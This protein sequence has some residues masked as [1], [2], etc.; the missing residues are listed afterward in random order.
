MAAAWAMLVVVA[1][2]LAAASRLASQA[3]PA[4]ARPTPAT[5]FQTPRYF[6]DRMLVVEAENFT[7]VG[8]GEG[9]NWVPIR[10]GE[11]NY[12][13]TTIDDVFL[14]RAGALHA[15]A[16]TTR[17]TAVAAVT[18]PQDGVF[19]RGIAHLP[20]RGR[21]HKSLAQKLHI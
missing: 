6:S 16:S 4:A 10:W 12:F 11:G 18:I 7:V 20:Q 17:A 3:G 9:G 15:P 2:P 8:D 21:P 19:R 1:L 14:S 13:C 5:P